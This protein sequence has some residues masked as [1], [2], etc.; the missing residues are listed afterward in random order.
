MRCGNG[1]EVNKQMKIGD[2]IEVF[3]GPFRTHATVVKITDAGAVLEYDHQAQLV[4]W[5]N[6]IQ[7]APNGDRLTDNERQGFIGR[8]HWP[9][10]VIVR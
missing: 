10:A 2:R 1:K 6:G 5:Q 3:H 8:A 9:A 4:G 7:H